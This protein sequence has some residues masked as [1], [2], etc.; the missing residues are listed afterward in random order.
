MPFLSSTLENG[1]PFMPSLEDYSKGTIASSFA[2]AQASLN[3]QLAGEG[4]VLPSGFA[5][6][7]HTNLDA[8]EG[9]AFDSSQVNNLLLNQ[10]AK[11]QAASML[12]PSQYFTGATGA[13]SSILSAP[14]VNSGGVGNFL[15]GALSGALNNVSVGS[16]GAWT[17]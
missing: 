11:T 6:Q 5:E 15:G 8:A 17:L 13:N 2:P 12:N 9:G 14:P 4:S 1:L 3:R 7:A 10:Q 16:G